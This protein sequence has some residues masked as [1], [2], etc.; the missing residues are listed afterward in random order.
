MA[1]VVNT[2][3][4]L[5]DVG[6][7]AVHPENPRR[8]DVRAIGKSLESHGFYGVVVAQRSSGHVLKGNHTLMAARDAGMG[9][10]PVAWVDVDDDEARRILLDDNRASDLAEYDEAG[11]AELVAELEGSARGLAGT[12]YDEAT[13][14]SKLEYHEVHLGGPL[15]MGHMLISYPLELHGDVWSV[16]E[17]IRDPRIKVRQSQSDHAQ[18]DGQ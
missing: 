10:V 11:L 18:A 1:R 12:L 5:V 2:K 17:A 15:S 14:E 13:D 7:L 8:G 3:V 4:E 6:R 9:K 16:V